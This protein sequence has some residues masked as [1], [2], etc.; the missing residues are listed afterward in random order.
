VPVAKRLLFHVHS[1]MKNG[2]PYRERKP[3]KKGRGKVPVE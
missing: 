2:K 1:M 3:G